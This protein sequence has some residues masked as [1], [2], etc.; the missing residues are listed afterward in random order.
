MPRQR[1]A[2]QLPDSVGARRAVLYARV[3]TKEQESEG[4]SLEAQLGLLRSY[5]ASKGLA[6][7]REYVES[8]TAKTAGRPVFAAM[9]KAIREGEASAIVVEKTDRLYRNLKDRVLVDEL[10][11]DLHLVKE[12]TI[13]TKNSRS[14]E[15]FIHDIKLVVAKSFIDN[16]REEITKGMTQKA[17]SG[18]WPSMAPIGYLNTSRGSI[19]TIEP[20]P[21]TAPKVAALF[22][23]FAEGSSSIALLA[24]TAEEIGLRTKA[25]KAIPRSSL[26]RT[27]RNPIYYGRIL[28][29]GEDL[30][31]SHEPIVTPELWR[32]VQAVLDGRTVEQ[33]AKTR[34]PYPLAGLVRC[35]KCGCLMSPYTAKGKY[36]YYACSGAKGCSRKGIRQEALMAEI[37]RV[38]EGLRIPSDYVPLIR[39]ALKEMHVEQNA[40]QTELEKDLARQ[41]GKLRQRL[42]RLYVDKLDD[43]VGP[44]QYRSLKEKTDAELEAVLAR[45]SGTRRA[46]GRSWEEN[47][48]FLDL[49]SNSLSEFK[50]ASAVRKQEMVRSLVS[51]FS[52]LDGEP[53]LTLRPWFNLLVRAN[54][55]L[56]ENEPKDELCA[57][58]YSGRDSNP[59]SSP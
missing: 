28:W 51:N 25:G 40:E 47:V 39:Q 38:L 32:R 35:G 26:H 44:E 53:L 58:W 19:K 13:L 50:V 21:E 52:V 59:R 36:V 15:R 30:P 55:Q 18:I 20:D 6:V 41:E 12:S 54:I 8:E 29:N 11:P 16:L 56:V 2:I 42:E 31:G 24:E 45:K 43:E 34:E 27:L 7:V 17:R 10:G 37:E 49:V 46:Q 1:K 3:S 14:H 9:L 5:A 23:R 22:A 48:A 33:P 4:F 57:D